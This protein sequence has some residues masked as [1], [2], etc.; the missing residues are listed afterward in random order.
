L[1]NIDLNGLKSINDNSGHSQG[2]LLLQ[3]F[4]AILQ[5]SFSGVGNVFRMGGDEFLVIV[6]KEQFRLLDQAIAAME[7]QE[8]KRSSQLPFTVDASYGVAYSEECSPSR[9][10]RVYAL[11][12]QR[13]YEMKRQKKWTRGSDPVEA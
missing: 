2:D 11:A 7:R 3:E 5:R 8:R 4:A 6:H 12:D 10:D 9:T 1:I 13:M